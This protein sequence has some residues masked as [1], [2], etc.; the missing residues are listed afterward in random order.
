M[1]LSVV[2]LQLVS[3]VYSGAVL[4][5]QMLSFDNSN[6]RL[7]DGSCCYLWCI[8]SCDPVFQFELDLSTGYVD[9][10]DI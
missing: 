5:L 10:V 4:Q 1:I 7:W 9:A 8:A 6:K 3:T 2:L